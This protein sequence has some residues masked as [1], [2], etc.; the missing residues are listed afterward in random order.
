MP[1]GIYKH[2]IEKEAPNYKDGRTLIKHYCIICGKEIDWQSKTKKCQLCAVSGKNSVS[3][4]HGN[5]CKNK[6]HYC[7]E[8]NCN[9]EICYENWKNGKGRCRS[10]AGKLSI[11]LNFKNL[12]LKPNKPEQLLNNLL[13]ELLPKE[14]KYVGNGK[15]IIDRFNPDFINC[16]GQKKIIELFGDY[17]HNRKDWKERD[18]RRLLAYNRLGFKT[19]IIWEHELR[20]LGKVIV[21][22]MEFNND[23]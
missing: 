10:C 5:C 6:K 13:Q 15:M 8:P 11:L 18:K 3:Y 16:N 17:W 2:K 14:Y 4:K 22:I 23:Y 12:K 19:L 1:K 20:N 9:N 21:K 7:K